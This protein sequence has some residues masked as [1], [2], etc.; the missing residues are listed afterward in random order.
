MEV[1]AVSKYIRMSP[2]KARLVVDMVR[3]MPAQDALNLLRFETKAAAVPVGKL[4]RS[5]VANA[6][7]NYGLAADELYIA[8]I[9]SDSGP[10]LRRGR[11]AARGRF[12]PILKRSTHLRVVLATRDE[13]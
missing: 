5:A 12:K 6:E 1:Q 9:A 10:T 3:G 8:E 11:F 13:E 7:E 4:I 2:R